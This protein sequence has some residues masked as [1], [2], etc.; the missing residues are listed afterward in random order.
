MNIIKDASRQNSYQRYLS[1][2]FDY[3]SSLLNVKNTI[4]KRDQ[5]Q[6]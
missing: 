4:L 5:K 6:Q 2:G 3:I 1:I